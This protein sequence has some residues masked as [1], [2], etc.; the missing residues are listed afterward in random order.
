MTKFHSAGPPVWS[1]CFGGP[2]TEYG[3]NIAVDDLSSVYV[4]GHFLLT[5][6]L[7]PDTTVAAVTS[8]G[9]FDMYFA[10]Y[11]QNTTIGLDESMG[12]NDNFQFNVYPNPFHSITNAELKNNFPGEAFTWSFALF[13]L[14]GKKIIKYESTQ[15][16]LTVERGNLQ[17]GLYFYKAESKNEILKTGKIVLID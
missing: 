11:N 8:N 14:A 5:A 2:S 16:H 12:S 4:T 7:D 13:D 9:G 3:F 6:D 17:P 15:P 10:K 1:K